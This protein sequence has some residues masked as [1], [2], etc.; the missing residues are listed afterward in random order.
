MLHS[1]GARFCMGSIFRQ[2]EAAAEHSFTLARIAI[3]N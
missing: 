2:P 1:D 3:F